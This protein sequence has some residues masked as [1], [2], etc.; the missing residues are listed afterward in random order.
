MKMRLSE[1]QDDNKKTKKLRLERPSKDRE[2]IKEVFYYQ[3][4]LYVPK[5]ICSKLISRYYNN[6]LV[7]P[8]QIEKTQELIARKYY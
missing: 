5:V 3:D 8:F 6:P 2:N 4:L 1:I 7:G